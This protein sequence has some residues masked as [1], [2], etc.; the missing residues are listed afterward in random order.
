LTEST[1]SVR[2]GFLRSCERF[3]ERPALAIGGRSLTYAELHERAASIAATLARRAPGD[4]PPLSAVLGQRS[5]TVYAG[6]LGALLRGHGYVPLNPA[7]P[8]AR[9]RAMLERSRCAAIVVDAGAEAHLE[10][11]LEGVERRLLLILPDRADASG[12]GPRAARHEVVA[13]DALEPAA[14][15]RPGPV[16]PNAIAYLLFTS[17]STGQPKGVMV[18][19]RNV[20]RFVDVMTERYD[21]RETDRFSQLFDLTFD[22]SAFDMFVAWERGACLAPPTSK[23]KLVPAGYVAEAGLTIWF[24]VPSTAVMLSRLGKLK[25]DTYPGLRLALFCGEALPQEVLEAWSLAAPKAVLE[26]LYGPTEVTIACTAYRWDPMRSPGECELGLVPIGEPYPGMSALI[27][28]EA[29]REVAPGEAGEL[30]MGGPQVSLGYWQDPER[31][32]A[33]F[34]RP[35]DRDAVFYRTGDRVRR[36]RPGG[37]LVYLGRVDNQIKIQGYRVE[38]EEVESVLRDAAGV[39][40]AIAIGWPVNAAGADGIVAFLGTEAADLDAVRQRL[41]QRLPPYMVP[42]ELR[43]HPAFELNANGKVDR[44]ALRRLLEEGA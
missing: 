43:L 18:A 1:R 33:A 17:G 14:A 19:H 22:L 10:E 5:E 24:S 4:D 34:V 41:R 13:G 30:L 35:P 36:V 21:V 28:D 25:P 27:A 31:S 3:G 42:R 16:D 40:V 29:L 20:T 37:P 23:Q 39:E 11:V 2:S 6:V 26:N 9:T 32:A 44:K 8:A 15:W 7:F 12:L 38:L